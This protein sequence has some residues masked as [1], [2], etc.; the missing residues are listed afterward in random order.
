MIYE[1]KITEVSRAVVPVR[2]DTPDEAQKIFTEW[3]QKHEEDPQDSLINDLLDNGYDG[4]KFERSTG[5]NEKEYDNKYSTIMLPEEKPVPQEPTFHLHIRFADG[6]EPVDYPHK[7]LK[8]IGQ[9]LYAWGDKYHLFPNAG[10]DASGCLLTEASKDIESCFWI[11]AVL[12]DK[13]ETW[14]EFEER[15]Y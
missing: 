1:F 5:F 4:R 9:E 2:A 15:D 14:Y 10:P 3:Y 7:T 6:S 13:P 8:E 12:K 11:Y